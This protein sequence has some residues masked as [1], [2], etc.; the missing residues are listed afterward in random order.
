LVPVASLIIRLCSHSPPAHLPLCTTFAKAGRV[1]YARHRRPRQL[2]SRWHGR[3]AGLSATAPKRCWAAWHSRSEGQGKMKSLGSGCYA[4]TS[5]V[6]AAMLAGCGGSQPP[7]GAPGAMAQASGVANHHRQGKSRSGDLMYLSGLANKSYVLAY[8]SGEFVGTINQTATAACA[9]ALGNVYLVGPNGV[10]A[11]AHGATQP[12]RTLSLP[13]VGNSC[14]VDPLTGDLAVT[15]ISKNDVAIF[16]NASG[17]P[18][19]YAAPY[20][21]SPQYCGYDNAG[22]LFIDARYN[23]GVVTLAEL[24]AKSGVFSIINLNPYSVLNPGQVQ[25]DGHHMTLEVGA[26]AKRPH[27]LT[28]FQLSISGSEA[29]VVGQTK[30][31]YANHAAEASW[32]YGNRIL[33]PFGVHQPVPNI[34][35]WPYPKGGKATKIIV[36]PSANFTGIAVSVGS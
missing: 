35:I 13:Y 14:S 34:G 10:S 19:V 6:A 1:C 25:W 16:K 26:F 4:L 21:F 23:S 9:D 15:L 36:G 30:F 3:Y 11:Y 24:P 20:G 8:P 5:S 32:I 22:D 17:S 28:I 29:Q 31:K 27:A 2:G 7:I 12:S 18:T 33:V